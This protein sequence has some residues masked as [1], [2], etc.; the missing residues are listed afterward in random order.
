VAT[1]FATLFVTIGILQ[2]T[3]IASSP[4]LSS[5]LLTVDEMPIGWTVVPTSVGGGVGCLKSVLEPKGVQQTSKA[6]SDFQNSGDT[7]EVLER[8]ATYSNTSEAFNKVVSELKGC[9]K[10]SGKTSG[11]T[12]TGTASEMSFPNYGSASS[13]FSVNLTVEGSKISENII[14]VRLGS[15]IM[16]L[17]EAGSPPV[18]LKQFEGF[19]SKAL[20]AIAGG[21]TKGKGTTPTTKPNPNSS[22]TIAFKDESGN[23][24]KVEVAK[25]VD[26]AQGSDS[27]MTP[28]EGFRFVAVLFIVTDTGSNQISDDADSDATVIGSNNQTYTAD[29]DTVSGCT[30]FNDGEYQLNPGQSATGCVTFQVP[31]R[32]TVTKVEWS[33]NF[34]FGGFGTWKVR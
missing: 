11:K 21:S 15:F 8:L 34:G 33:P 32:V 20:K 2:G 29:F 6:D 7:V 27:F 12:V 13:A 25:L 26:P 9:K 10:I 16:G 28:N 19:V 23:P 24:Y 14:V 30:N 5:K 18:S 3:V 1:F 31:V 4:S 22:S 17:S